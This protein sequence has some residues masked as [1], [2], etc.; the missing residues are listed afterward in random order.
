MVGSVVK[1][2]TGQMNGGGVGLLLFVV[3]GLAI[4]YRYVPAATPQAVAG[5]LP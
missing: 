5:R 4:L 1:G 3:L 2:V